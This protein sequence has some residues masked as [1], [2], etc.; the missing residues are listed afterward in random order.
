MPLATP[1]VLLGFLLP[2]TWGTSSWLLQ[3]S[4][5][6]AP[7]LV[8]RISP[9]PDLEHGVAPLGHRAPAQPPLPLLGCGVANHDS[10]AYLTVSSPGQTSLPYRVCHRGNLKGTK[11]GENSL[12]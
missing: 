10:Q 5:A 3:Q 9:P 11:V 6:A 7:Y 2:W 12:Q 8:Q 4:T 1:T